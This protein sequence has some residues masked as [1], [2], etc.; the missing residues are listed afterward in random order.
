[1]KKN[2]MRLCPRGIGAL[3]AILFGL[4]CGPAAAASTKVVLGYVPAVT[5]SYASTMLAAELG[6]F[7]EEGIDISFVEFKG[8]AILLPQLVNKS[9]TIGYPNPDILIL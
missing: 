6:Y 9:V 7:K 8:S 1:M 2:Q 5:I 4:Y 3:S